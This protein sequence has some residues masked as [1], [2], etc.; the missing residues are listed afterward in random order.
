M[1]IQNTPDPNPRKVPTRYALND[2]F[3]RLLNEAE[4]INNTAS[5]ARYSPDLAK[6]GISATI[7]DAQAADI[8]SAR[9]LMQ[10]THTGRIAGKTAT[11]P[12]TAARTQMELLAS[13]I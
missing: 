5:D 2:G 3:T 8:A 13:Q 4:T 9:G 12:Q 11:G 10:N 1:Q 6:R 7:T